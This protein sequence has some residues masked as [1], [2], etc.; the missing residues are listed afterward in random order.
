MD[1]VW[2]ALPIEAGIESVHESQWE[3]KEP[4]FVS[5]SYVD[6]EIIRDLRDAVMPSFEK[7]RTAGL[8]GS[9]LD[10]KI[11]LNTNNTELLGVLK[12]YFE[13]L[14]RIFI[15]SQVC[16]LDDTR[17]EIEEIA[18]TLSPKVKNAQLNEARVSISVERA[19]GNKCERC[20]NYSVQ[21]G[22][23]ADHPTLCERCVE[24]IGFSP[25]GRLT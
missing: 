5:N 2:K 24:V 16:W 17:E 1:E 21:V 12:K 7:K 20:W 8:I 25:S 10:A 3:V 4:A 11:Y 19:D 14:R 15:V 22:N 9:S 13:D 18:F 23:F 6:W